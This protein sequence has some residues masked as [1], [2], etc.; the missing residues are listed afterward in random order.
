MTSDYGK[1][2]PRPLGPEVTRPFWEGA[3]ERRL[4]MPRCTACGHMFFYPRSECPECM[5]D[6]IEW[7]QVSGSGTV[8]SFTIVRQ[9]A[10]PAFRDDVP[11]PYA[12]VELDEGP[13][14]VTTIV[15]CDPEEVRI[16]MRVTTVFDDVTPEWTLVKFRPEGPMTAVRQG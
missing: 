11:Y 14:M 8:Y 4:V 13:R 16:G 10:D 15:G 9:P 2:V 12:I 7:V 3:R 5:A 6:G 1:P